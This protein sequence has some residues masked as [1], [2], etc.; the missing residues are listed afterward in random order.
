MRCPGP[1]FN[2]HDRAI[3]RDDARHIITT[4]H[5]DT[6]MPSLYPTCFVDD[7]VDYKFLGNFHLRLVDKYDREQNPELWL[8]DY[9]RTMQLANEYPYHAIKYLPIMLKGLARAWLNTLPPKSIFCW[10]NIHQEFLANFM[11]TYQRPVSRHDLSNIIQED[12]KKI[13]EFLARWLK[14]KNETVDI[15][16]DEAITKFRDDC[17]DEHLTCDLG[18]ATLRNM[19]DLMNVATAYASG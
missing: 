15:M 5:A 4:M 10:K 3:R 14:K 9:I 1:P 6:D 18:N 17:R 11:G 12:G 13:R 19:M 16:S 2:E 8:A 7:I